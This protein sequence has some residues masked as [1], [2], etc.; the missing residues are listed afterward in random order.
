M[1]GDSDPCPP[2]DALALRHALAMKD[3]QRGI[4]Q[5]ALRIS[6]EEIE[7]AKENLEKAREQLEGIRQWDSIE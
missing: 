4:L 1:M 2:H 3:E 5:A 7:Q 6:R